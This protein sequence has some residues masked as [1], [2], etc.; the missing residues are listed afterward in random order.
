[1]AVHVRYNSW[2]IS[3]PTSTRRR[4]EKTREILYCPENMNHDGWFFNFLFQ[5]YR[6]PDLHLR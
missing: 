4:R 2:Y 6:V 5:I 1:M 3:M